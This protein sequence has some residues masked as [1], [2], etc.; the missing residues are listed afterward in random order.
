MVSVDRMID[1]LWRGEPPPR[2]IASL[3][4]YVSNLRRLL[5]LSLWAC[6]RQAEALAALRRA[7]R[8]LRDELGL[9]PGPALAEVEEAI[10][11][12]YQEVLHRAQPPPAPAAPAASCAGGP[13]ASCA[14]RKPDRPGRA[15]PGTGRPVRRAWR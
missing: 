7:R 12:Q 2:A 5:A 4:A 3:Q 11:G 8:I 13:A 10:L 6:D 15:G 14:G 1:Q 9:E